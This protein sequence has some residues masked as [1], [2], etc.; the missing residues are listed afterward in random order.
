[1]SVHT[2]TYS[3]MHTCIYLQVFDEVEALVVSVLDGYNVC[4]F[5]YGQTGSGKTYTM[6]SKPVNRVYMPVKTDTCLQIQ[7][8]AHSSDY[9]QR[10]HLVD[11]DKCCGFI[12]VYMCVCVYVCTYPHKYI[13]IYTYT[14]T[15]THINIHICAKC[16][17][18]LIYWCV[19]ANVSSFTIETGY[20][21]TAFAHRFVYA[22][23]F[24]CMYACA[25]TNKHVQE[26]ND[27][28]RG[29]RA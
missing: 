29:T 5:A 23:V 26:G 14:F 2:H 27:S 15:H 18:L 9:I 1:M 8:C 22:D 4:I 10:G 19:L 12:T 21:L 3:H 25:H 20:F 13:H 7:T 17:H 16:T 6:V 11:L 24:V 28:D